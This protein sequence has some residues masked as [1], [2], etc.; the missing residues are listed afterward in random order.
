M[1]AYGMAHDVPGRL[2]AMQAGDREGRN[3]SF[4]QLA[5]RI[6]H[7]GVRSE[8][9]P[10]TVPFLVRM[11]LDENQAARHEIVG[12]LRVIAIGLDTDLLSH[13]GYDPRQDRE[14]LAA[15]RAEAEAWT[16][17]WNAD[18]EAVWQL[19]LSTS[20]YAQPLAEA[21][22][23]VHSYDAVREALPRLTA[24]LDAESPELR[25][26]TAYLL[27]WFPESAATSVPLLTAFVAGE[28][29]PGAAATSLVALGLLGDLA[30]VPVLRRY[31]DSP[32]PEARWAS[33]FALNRLG[34][35][36][37]AVVN[38]LTEL[39]AF[40]PE[41]TA[42]LPFLSGPGATF[43]SVIEVDTGDNSVWGG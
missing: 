35:D 26:E 36:D 5:N 29:S 42:T 24:L 8:A 18:A 28:G 16:I 3:P 4:A 11:A 2:R 32:N 14:R 6:V 20:L 33:A 41:N 9:A 1:H 25:A 38:V 21:E 43:A 34:V 13:G 15:V 10:Y 19:T 27:A 23:V 17:A 7:N 22:R 37:S 39:G 30:A 31:L 12:L 40:R